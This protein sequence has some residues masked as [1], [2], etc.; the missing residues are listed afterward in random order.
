M[1]LYSAVRHSYVTVMHSTIR[2]W[3]VYHFC[4]SFLILFCVV[5]ERSVVFYYFY[6][7]ST[8]NRILHVILLLFIVVM[9]VI[10]DILS[11]FVVNSNYYDFLLA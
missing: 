6:P 8:R 9:E 2:S 1:L 10:N 5:A 11:E 4:Y 3:S 7:V